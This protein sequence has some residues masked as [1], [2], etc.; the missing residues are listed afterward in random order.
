MYKAVKMKRF[1]NLILLTI[2]HCSTIEPSQELRDGYFA[3]SPLRDFRTNGTN[4]RKC[5]LD[6]TTDAQVGAGVVTNISGG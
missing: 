5:I 1:S 4:F 6:E 2:L 3:V